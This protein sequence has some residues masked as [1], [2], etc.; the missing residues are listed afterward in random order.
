MF[1]NMFFK[2]FRAST[3]PLA[4]SGWQH[5]PAWLWPKVLKMSENTSHVTAIIQHLDVYVSDPHAAQWAASRPHC[6]AIR[7]QGY[8]N[9]Y[10]Y[11]HI[12]IRVYL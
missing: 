8:C 2:S 11:T 3:W 7:T 10:E 4:S 6:F 1:T 9:I 5:S 12:C